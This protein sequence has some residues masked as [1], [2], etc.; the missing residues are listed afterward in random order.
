VQG[1]V[2]NKKKFFKA[3]VSWQAALCIGVLLRLLLFLVDDSLW[4]DEAK[5]LMSLYLVPIEEIFNELPYDQRCPFALSMLWQSMIENGMGSNHWIRLPSLVAGISQLFIFAFIIRSIFKQNNN[6]PNLV[7]WIAAVSPKLIL[8]SNQVKQYI[9]DVFFSTL[10]IAFALPFFLKE[11]QQIKQSLILIL[12]SWASLF[13]SYTATFVVGGICVGLFI[14]YGFRR[15]WL[16]LTISLGLAIFV[17]FILTASGETSLYLQNFWNRDFPEAS[18]V[19]WG[20]ALAHSFFFGLSSPTYI[21]TKEFFLLFGW[22]FLPLSALGII[23]LWRK[24]QNGLLCLLL[25]PSLFCLAASFLHKYP[26]GDRL[27]L[28]MMPQILILLGFGLIYILSYPRLKLMVQ[29]VLWTAIS[30]CLVLSIIEYSYPCKGIRYGLDYIASREKQ[31]DIIVVD[32]YASQVVR[33]YQVL[34]KGD[35]RIKFPHAEFVFEWQDESKY[36][37]RPTPDEIV[38]RLPSNSRIWI[39]A[40]FGYRH[41]HLTSSTRGFVKEMQHILMKSRKELYHVEVPRLLVICFSKELF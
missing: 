14:N 29:G 22:L 23:N 5:L 24:K 33:Y 6:L 17:M 26:Y 11:K 27:I 16:F 31:G 13:F 21:W 7:I 37:G 1:L 19:W 9:F 15:L 20:K 12:V 3:I 30:L 18:I 34:A 32:L 39:I 35:K 2:F 8:Y 38:S 4:R 36:K 25:F 41:R 40:E 10:L 28:F